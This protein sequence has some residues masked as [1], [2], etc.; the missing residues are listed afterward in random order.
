M[1]GAKFAGE[2]LD[3][4]T[5]FLS[6]AARRC[7][8]AQGFLLG[9]DA[10][11]EAAPTALARQDAPTVDKTDY[12]EFGGGGGGVRQVVRRHGLLGKFRLT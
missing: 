9:V 8:Q 1:E 2:A 10:I 12:D 5:D 3:Q 7:S 11:V 6:R 4:D